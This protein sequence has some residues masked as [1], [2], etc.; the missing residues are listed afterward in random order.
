MRYGDGYCALFKCGDSAG[1]IVDLNYA[2]VTDGVIARSPDSFGRVCLRLKVN[3]IAN[4]NV[5]SL[6]REFD[7][8]GRYYVGDY[9]VII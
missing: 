2:R 9:G 3:N 5:N 6:F 7:V 8:F 4:V 1:I